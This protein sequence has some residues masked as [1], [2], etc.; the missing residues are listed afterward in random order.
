MENRVQSSPD[1]TQNS[2]DIVEQ[3][4]GFYVALQIVEKIR[5]AL[6]IIRS[7]VVAAWQAFGRW[8]SRRQLEH[9]RK[10]SEYR[11]TLP[12]QIKIWRRNLSNRRPHGIYFTS[13]G[14]AVYCV[15]RLVRLEHEYDR[16][17]NPHASTLLLEVLWEADK[18]ATGEFRGGA[19]WKKPLAFVRQWINRIFLQRA[20]NQVLLKEKEMQKLSSHDHE[21]LG[22]AFMILGKFAEAKDHFVSA[23]GEQ[24]AWESFLQA[25]G[26]PE[27]LATIPGL[28]PIQQPSRKSTETSFKA[29]Q[30]ERLAL[31]KK[32]TQEERLALDQIAQEERLALSKRD[33]TFVVKYLALLGMLEI[34]FVEWRALR[35]K[36]SEKEKYAELIMLYRFILNNAVLVQDSF[37]KGQVYYRLFSFILALNREHR[38][39]G[40]QEDAIPTAELTSRSKSFLFL[41]HKQESD[42]FLRPHE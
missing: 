6:G 35:V 24:K 4:G 42:L 41:P 5:N 32:M 31:L 1:G 20:L 18:A 29:A 17:Y 40:A 19:L 21:V 38:E 30:E 14:G 7:E 2:A 28:M 13:N 37:F 15:K 12:S 26:K 22:R 34:L 27:I 36:S 3:K 25:L 39:R 23:F 10:D 11:Q 33:F 9:Q 16:N 8:Q